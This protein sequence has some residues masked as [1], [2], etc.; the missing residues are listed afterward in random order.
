MPGRD[1]RCD[2]CEIGGAWAD[3][4]TTRKVQLNDVHVFMMVRGGGYSEDNAALICNRC[5]PFFYDVR[6]SFKMKAHYASWLSRH[7]KMVD[8]RN[9]LLASSKVKR[10][11]SEVE[12][13][14]D[15]EFNRLLGR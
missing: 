3:D 4:R 9:E 6:N 8:V 14:D 15:D 2:R 1:S 13:V 12:Q 10:V 5:M 11:G 7:H